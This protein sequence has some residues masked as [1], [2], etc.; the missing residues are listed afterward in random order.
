[1]WDSE[2]EMWSGKAEVALG[3]R[4]GIHIMATSDPADLRRAVERSR[5]GFEW[6]LASERNVRDTITLHLIDTHN[7]NRDP[8]DQV[9]PDG[10][11]DRLRLESAVFEPGGT[12]ELCYKDGWLFGGHWVVVTIDG[13]RNIG[14][15]RLV[16]Y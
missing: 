7:G 4:I 9:T 1:M 2:L 3:H 12:I 5:A 13:D 15:V 16:V 10:F 6:L 14:Q 11:A 8:E